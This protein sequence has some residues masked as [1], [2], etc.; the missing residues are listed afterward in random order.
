MLGNSITV[1][2]ERADNEVRY[3]SGMCSRVSQGGRQGRFFV[4][5]ATVR[6]WLWMLTRTRNYQIFQEKTVPEILKE[7]FDQHSGIADVDVQLTES[8][9]PWVYCVQYNESDFAF[10]SRLMEHEGIYYF[11]RHTNGG[12]H[13]LVIADSPAAHTPS[14]EEEMP[15]IPP[16]ERVRP[17][18]EHISEWAVTREL[19]PGKYALASYDFEKPSVD[20]QVR[21]SI[22][23]QHALAEYEVFDF[24]GDYVERGDGELYARMRIEEVQAKFEQTRGV[25][26]ARAMAPGFLFN[27]AQ[28]PRGDQNAEY[29]VVSA[30]Y[31]LRSGEHEGSESAAAEYSCR[32]SALNSK[33]PFRAERITPKPV[34]QGLTTALVVGPSGEEIYTDN[35]GRVKVQFFWDRYGTYDEKSSCWIRV[36]QNWGGKNWGGMFI[37]HLGQEVIVQFEGGDPDLPLITGRVYNAA[38]MPPVELPAGKTQSVIRDH[39]ANSIILE[40]DGGKQ[41]IT[42]YSPTMKTTIRIGAFN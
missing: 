32:F 6:P 11:F 29:L 25:T 4:Y 31:D 42:M 36:A 15:F 14:Y 27:L 9:T 40:G 2:L 33:Q 18:Q 16:H 41:R 26:N 5:H 37:P 24:G 19:Q 22:T 38:N 21:S 17:E 7:I 39:G 28:H 3:F 35:Y 20:L 13:T 8:Y 12:K 1:A 10:V 30:E 23:R 34:A